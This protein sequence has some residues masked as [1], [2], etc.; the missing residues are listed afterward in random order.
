MTADEDLEMD[1][2]KEMKKQLA[3]NP[4]FFHISWVSFGLAA[5]SPCLLE[6]FMMTA[7]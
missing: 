3:R 7:T 6:R 1:L 5:L 4:R 2:E